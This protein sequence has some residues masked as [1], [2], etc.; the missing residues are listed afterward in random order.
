MTRLAVLLA[1]TAL[2]A[3]ASR[4]APAHAATRAEIADL[5][6]G[7]AAVWA[8]RQDPQGLFRDPRTGAPVEGY[9]NAMLGYALLR[10]GERRGDERLIASG[11]R[12][13]GTTLDEPPAMRGVF[14][15]L[16]VASAYDFA[17]AHLVDDAA[18][19]A[20]RPRWEDYLR[21]TLPPNIDNEVYDCIVAT[22][23]F[24]NHEAVGAAAEL[25][26]LATGLTSTQPGA[27]LA[28][29]AALRRT[30]LAEVGVAEPAFARGDA[31]WSGGE[32]TEQ[33]LA[34]LSDTGNFPLA[35]HALSTAMLARSVQLLGA[36]APD[37]ARA[38]LRRTTGALAALMAPD[39]AV[40][41]IGKRQESVWSLA[42][43]VASAE[44]AIRAGDADDGA[45]ERYRA[46]SDRA[47]ARI[48]ARY[49]LTSRGLPIVPRSGPD[50][51]SPDGVDGDPMT[52]NGLA[53]L[54]LDLAA[55]AAPEDAGDAAALPADADGAF[56]DRAQ[57]EFAAVRHGDVWFAVHGQD[58]PRDVRNDFG[59][60]AA[61]WRAPSGGWVDVLRPR[62]M[63]FD[64]GETAGPVVE[65]GGRRL[66]PTGGPI[67]VRGGGRVE[68]AGSLG[69]EPATFTFFPAARGV[70]IAMPARAGD[71]VTY[72]AYLPAAEARVGA[73]GAAVSD[74][75]AAVTATPPPASVRLD[76]GFSSCC[77]VRL[78]AAR[79]RVPVRAD[80]TVSFTVAAR[81]DARWPAPIGA[82]ADGGTTRWWIA[83]LALLA[84][85]ALGLALRRRA[86][87]R[88]RRRTR[89][90][91]YAAPRP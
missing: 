48:R 43:T 60:V 28:D 55:D 23:C 82:S 69:G 66:V 32:R 64:D 10:A 84:A 67:A 29:R 81:A 12:G 68:V 51:F 24:H 13:I 91:R 86:V 34:L 26:L 73:D 53:L 45:R 9:G 40:A 90:R 2:L 77:D 89:A 8:G 52:F 71:V 19:K 38:A 75:D 70:R 47:L 7:A 25:E 88:R 42:A 6:D 39:G 61:K 74:R 65:R 79:I 85:S 59:L 17:R 72:S 33:G 22:G 44:I 37:A 80:G 76:D 20:V 27:Q 36:A 5:A 56:V 78:V 58:R 30:A 50:A 18:V 62:P 41:Y 57:N 35:Y 21:A 46:A 15:V 4:P 31:G 11:V 3:A 1:V 49:P 63:R 16:S 83:A 14:D 54:L 87:V